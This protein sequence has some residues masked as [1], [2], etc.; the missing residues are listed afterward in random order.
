MPETAGGLCL[1]FLLVA[2]FAGA[3]L[4]L[5]NTGLARSRS[6]AHTMLMAV[7]VGAVAVLAFFVCGFAW[8][9]LA[10]APSHAVRLAGKGWDWI[11]AGGFFLRGVNLSASRD[12]LTVLM[13]LESVALCAMIP[14]ATVA[15]RWRLGACCASTAV[16]AGWTYPLFAHWVWGGGWLAQM[17]VTYHLGRGFV[18]PGGASCIHVVGGLTALSLA[19]IVGPRHAK[20]SAHG[21]PTAMPG[22]NAVI[23]LFGCVLALVGFLGLNSAGALLFG[24]VD[25]GQMVVVEVNTLL[26]A[27]AAAIGALLT[28]RV[29]FGRPDASLT[30]NGWVSGL[31]ASSAIV[32]FVRPAEAVLV[33]LIAGALVIFAVETI[34]LRMKVDDP[35]GAIAVHS[36]G[37]M[38]GIVALGMFG[39]FGQTG[40]SSDGQFLAQLIGVATLLGFGLPLSYSVNWAINR[41]VPQR[42]AMEGERQG[43]DLFELGA[44]AYPEFVT[45]REDFLRR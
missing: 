12:S 6:A 28:T 11:G 16:L 32:P 18:D 9:G 38:W 31:V 24:G 13:Q 21:M 36:L 35:A 42:V 34:E 15:E 3:G 4:S 33:G 8:A 29:R 25:A 22:H 23:V 45:H 41:I 26:C 37:G 40:T 19:W 1:L 7:S 5:M 10:G 20:F 14:A 17:G 30:A 27:A 2:P 39:R 43:M 44:G